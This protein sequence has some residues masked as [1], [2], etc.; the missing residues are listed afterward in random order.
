VLAIGLI[1]LE[2]LV[3][4]RDHG[5]GRWFDD[6]DRARTAMVDKLTFVDTPDAFAAGKMNR[7]AL[8]SNDGPAR[9]VI[10]AKPQKGFPREGTWTSPQVRTD[11][12]FTE[13][14]P[15]WNLITPT[16][17]GVFFDVRAR[18]ISSGKWSPWLRIG[19][20]GRTTSSRRRD[21]AE[22]ARIETDTLFL[23]RPA[24]AYQIRA[25]LQ[26]YD[27]ADAN[28]TPA[29]RRIAVVYSGPV[30]ANSVWAKSIDPGP[31]DGW[32]RS[33]DVPYIPQGDNADA[34]TGMTCSPTS[35]SM[36][37]RYW[38]VERPT[39]E[40]VLAIWDDHNDLFGNWS[41]ATQR[42]A[43]LG[44]DAWLERFRTWDQVKAKIAA[45]QPVVASILYEKGT[46]DE[47]ETLEQRETDGHLLVI[48][49]FTP[50]GDVIV[51]DPA[52]RTIGNG[53][54]LSARG[55]G[56]A[57]FGTKGGLGYVIRPPANPLPASMIVKSPA[58]QP[59]GATTAP[60]A[61]GTDPE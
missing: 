22:W 38:G 46:F 57:W 12:P 42:A 18:D 1:S 30:D 40:N 44:M 55:M 43:E 5:D 4:L 20:W 37:L 52:K 59:I 41:N 19:A 7:T 36:V 48:R 9:V 29:V 51:N 10:S 6:A 35:V 27:L 47:S 33:L 15:S 2:A 28:T 3:V 31:A 34:V 54:V 45:G 23:K 21:D 58:T 50:R 32:A 25:T 56:H 11:F 53:L 39:M 17:T 8:T 61:R 14:V 24:D 16:G 26:S 13:M 49:G 60:V